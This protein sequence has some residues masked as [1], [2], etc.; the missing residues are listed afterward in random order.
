MN[1]LLNNGIVQ[2]VIATLICAA[3]FWV[4]NWFRYKKDESKILTFLQDSIEKTDFIFRSEHAI[5]SE[6]NLSEE[7]V[8]N[9]C[10]KSSKTT[11]NQKEKKSWRLAGCNIKHITSCSN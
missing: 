1:E 11:R 8:H 2:A 4:F 5:S 6:T 3:I 10:S 9:I 7:R